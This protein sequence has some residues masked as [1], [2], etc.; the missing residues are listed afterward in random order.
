MKIKIYQINFDRDT[1]RAKFMGLSKLK[2]DIDPSSYDEVF[3]LFCGW[4]DG[5]AAHRGGQYRFR[6]ESGS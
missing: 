6:N 4:P 5:R 3:R 1:A 2:G